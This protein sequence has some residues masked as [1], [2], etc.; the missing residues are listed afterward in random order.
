MIIKAAGLPT[1]PH[2][3]APEHAPS[4]IPVKPYTPNILIAATKIKTSLR[5]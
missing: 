2:P 1:G 5:I 4:A 3:L